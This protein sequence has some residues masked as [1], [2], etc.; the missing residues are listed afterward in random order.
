MYALCR[1]YARQK[2]CILEVL[3]FFFI[4]ATKYIQ[5]EIYLENIEIK[6][7]Y[8]YEELSLSK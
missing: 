6:Y 1:R 8:K 7:V 3:I 5:N 4:F 2:A